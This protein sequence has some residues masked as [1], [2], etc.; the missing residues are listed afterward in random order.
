[1]YSPPS[2]PGILERRQIG[3]QFNL[4]DAARLP[5]RPFS[6]NR[7]LISLF[8]ILGGL[9]VGLGLIALLEY[10]DSTFKTDSE[11]AGVLALPVLA[12]VPL[13]RSD[14]E[15]RAEFRKRLL[16]NLGLGS[17]VL[18]CLAVLTYT[19]VFVR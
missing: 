16:L 9:A 17:T 4:L 18:V 2:P 5:E 11:L 12:V 8:G 10:R 13:M 1:M 6:P 14:A 15:R 3:E 19:F 7:I